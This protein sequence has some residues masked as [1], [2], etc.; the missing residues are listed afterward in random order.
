MVGQRF[1][2]PPGEYLCRFD[3]CRLRVRL[4][5]RSKRFEDRET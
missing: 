2:K 1:A 4:K 5:D 3:S